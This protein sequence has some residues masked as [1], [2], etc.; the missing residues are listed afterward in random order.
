MV[1]AEDVAQHDE[2]I[3]HLLVRHVVRLF[4]IQPVLERKASLHELAAAILGA[5]TW[6]S[7]VSRGLDRTCKRGRFDVIDGWDVPS[8]L[9]NR[10]RPGQVTG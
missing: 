6:Q 3:L 10:S 9:T 5:L 1:V 7:N 2:Q 4:P 8:L